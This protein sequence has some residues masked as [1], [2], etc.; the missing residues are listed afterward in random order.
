VPRGPDIDPV[1]ASTVSPA[2]DKRWL[3]NASHMGH[4]FAYHRI[5]LRL[6][7]RRDLIGLFFRRQPHLL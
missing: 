7:A 3:A 5:V 6:V 4:N 1:V 2:N